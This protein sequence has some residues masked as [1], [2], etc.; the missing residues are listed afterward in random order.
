LKKVSSSLAY[1]ST[2]CLNLRS[3]HIQAH[4]QA[5]T[6]A[7]HQHVQL[8]QLRS[9]VRTGTSLW[10]F[11]LYD[12]IQ[13][14]LNDIGMHK[15]PNATTI[16]SPQPT[17]CWQY[18]DMLLAVPQHVAGST[19]TCCWQYRKLRFTLP[20]PATHTKPNAPLPPVLTTAGP[21]RQAAS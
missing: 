19:A 2:Y 17:C 5:H 11:L 9:F 18:R 3:L 15:G 4:T 10:G 21:C 13:N 8:R 12:S 16:S 14:C 7:A 6:D 20:L 1:R